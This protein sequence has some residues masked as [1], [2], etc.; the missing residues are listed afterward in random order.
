MEGDTFA[1]GEALN[2][3]RVL[4]DV[5]EIVQAIIAN[6]SQIQI[7]ELGDADEFDDAA[8][9]ND[10][11]LMPPGETCSPCNETSSIS[12]KPCRLCPNLAMLTPE[13]L[14]LPASFSLL[15]AQCFERYS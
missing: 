2:V 4:Q 7:G 15:N 6:Q 8:A 1:E 12:G 3:M 13:I 14:L 11:Y 9:C 5:G 10:A